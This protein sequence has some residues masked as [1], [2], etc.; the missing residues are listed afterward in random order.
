MEREILKK[1]DELQVVEGLEFVP[2]GAL[3]L[4]HVAGKVLAFQ[5]FDVREPDRAAVDSPPAPNMTIEIP[6]ASASE[7]RS[8]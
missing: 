7:I 4:E 6:T 8:P 2:E 1:A 5:D 3:V